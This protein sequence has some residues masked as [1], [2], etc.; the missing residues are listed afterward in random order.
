MFQSVQPQRSKTSHFLRCFTDGHPSFILHISTDVCTNVMVPALKQPPSLHIST[1][2][3]TAVG[4]WLTQGF[5]TV[6]NPVSFNTAPWDDDFVH[7]FV[8]ATRTSYILFIHQPAHNPSGHPASYF[9]G[10]EK[11]CPRGRALPEVMILCG[12]MEDH[13]LVPEGG[14]FCFLRGWIIC[15]CGCMSICLGSIAGVSS[16]ISSHHCNL[17]CQDDNLGSIPCP[18]P[19][20]YAPHP[21]FWSMGCIF[22]NRTLPSNNFPVD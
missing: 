22:K 9:H 21:S 10:E 17:R 2:S 8:C 18:I 20:A 19:T 1:D 15:S 4:Y 16:L 13:F 5:Y 12:L 6:P 14:V 11:V 7:I 3:D